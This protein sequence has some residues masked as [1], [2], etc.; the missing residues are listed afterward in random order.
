MKRLIL[1]LMPVFFVTITKAQ[2]FTLVSAGK[3]NTR[4]IIPEKASVVEIQAAKVFQDYIQR[5]SGGGH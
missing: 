3:S 5:I 4:I 2:Q 1:L